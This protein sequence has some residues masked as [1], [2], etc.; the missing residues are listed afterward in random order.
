MSLEERPV[1]GERES[2]ADGEQL[3]KEALLCDEFCT[4][5]R[6]RCD[7][8]PSPPE[9]QVVVGGRPGGES[10]TKG[11]LWVNGYA[12]CVTLLMKEDGLIPSC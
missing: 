5:S 1:S 2:R 11:E 3:L 8:V 12:L 9:L 7:S 4:R 6:A 10:V